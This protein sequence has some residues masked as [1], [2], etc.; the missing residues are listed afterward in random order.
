V[1]IS[2]ATQ[3]VPHTLLT[4][5]WTGQMNAISPDAV[6]SFY[7]RLVQENISVRSDLYS[8]WEEPTRSDDVY[9]PWTNNQ[10]SQNTVRLFTSTKNMDQ[11][12]GV[13]CPALNRKTTGDG[14][15]SIAAWRKTA[16]VA[17]AF[18]S[19]N[20]LWISGKVVLWRVTEHCH[21]PHCANWTPESYRL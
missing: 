5:V 20:D 2:T 4:S 12:C 13:C 21:N 18:H 15:V 3:S 16:P 1:T 8:D 14:G 7:P 9:P 10:H 19:D 17:R 6:Y 11:D